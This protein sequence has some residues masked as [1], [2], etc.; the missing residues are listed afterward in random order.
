MISFV[1]ILAVIAILKTMLLV[2]ISQEVLMK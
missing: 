2:A 1:T